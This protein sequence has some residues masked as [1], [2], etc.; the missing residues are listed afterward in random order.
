[1]QAMA[2]FQQA[3]AAAMQSALQGMQSIPGLNVNQLAAS[4]VTGA[5]A[6]QAYTDTMTALAMQQ[7]AAAAGQQ[8]AMQSAFPFMAQA[9]LLAWQQAQQQAQEKAEPSPAQN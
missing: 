7:A 1:M 8:L 4:P 9:G 3:A 6:Q 2:N 5:N